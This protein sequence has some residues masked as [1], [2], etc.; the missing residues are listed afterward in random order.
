MGAYR[1]NFNCT[2]NGCDDWRKA[3]SSREYAEMN[4]GR[5]G[6]NIHEANRR[7]EIPLT[8]CPDGLKRKIITRRVQE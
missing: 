7:A 4:C 5:C 2:K 3:K 6:F 8:P 1:Q